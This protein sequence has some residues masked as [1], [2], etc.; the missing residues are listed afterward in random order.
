MHWNAPRSEIAVLARPGAPLSVGNGGN[1]TFAE[2]TV[3]G[4][5]APKATLQ[6]QIARNV[7]REDR[8]ETAGRCHSSGSPAAR[9]PGKYTVSHRSRSAGVYR[10]PLALLPATLE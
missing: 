7:D 4:E 3:K 8:G 10:S 9:I 6:P 2:G 1:P 5:L